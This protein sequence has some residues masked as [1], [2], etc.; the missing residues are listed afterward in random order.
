[1][2]T[3][4]VQL[5]RGFLLEELHLF[6]QTACKEVAIPSC[7]RWNE[8]SLAVFVHMQWGKRHHS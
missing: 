3:D 7:S 2:G 5:I 1:M 8:E 6:H 4:E